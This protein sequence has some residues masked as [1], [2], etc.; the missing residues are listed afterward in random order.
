[1]PFTFTPVVDLTSTA[2]T[3]HAAQLFRRAAR[4]GANVA[5]GILGIS[6]ALQLGH[7]T[8]RLVTEAM[9]RDPDLCIA[10]SEPGLHAAR[11]LM[12]RGRRV[13]VDM[14][15]WFSEDL[16]PEARRHRPL[17]LLRALETLLLACS[18]F[19]SSTSR[20]LCDAL[21]RNYG[22][23]APTVIYN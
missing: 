2:W 23:D 14:E 15:D 13:G 8:R 7:S 6:S 18:A 11:A 19:A 22:C 20:T 12:R 4:K 3:D 5:H 21:A 16:L 1:V 17:A 9:R 10:H